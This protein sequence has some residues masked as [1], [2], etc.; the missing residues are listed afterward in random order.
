MEISQ[1][2]YDK[3]IAE[4]KNAEGAQ[5]AA[6]SEATTTTTTETPATVAEQVATQTEGAAAT[7]T[8]TGTAPAFDE[9]KWLSENFGDFKSVEEIKQKLTAAPQVVQ[10]TFANDSSRK[11]YEALAS[12][13]EMAAL[14]YLEAKKMSE[15]ASAM[16]DDDLIIAKIKVDMPTLTEAQAKRYFER[17]YSVD[18]TLITDPEDIELEKAIVGDKKKSDASAAKQYFTNQVSEIQFPTFEQKQPEMTQLSDT[19]KQAMSFGQTF[20]DDFVSEL[21]FEFSPTNSPVKVKGQISL[22]PEQLKEITSKIGDNP[23]AFIAGFM[24]ARWFNGD[25]KSI[26]VNAVARDILFLN[27]ART[28]SNKIAEQCVNQALIAKLQADKNIPIEGHD[29]NTTVTDSKEAAM[30]KFFHIPAEQ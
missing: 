17:K 28:I 8:A 22:Q 2:I 29:T 21:P 24:Q 30:D 1:A 10:P 12:G 9:G 3:V 4:E 5:P 18:E 6:T 19:A 20:S 14:P 16:S 26:N 15:A 7:E 13:N 23:D 27:D 25:G 11:L